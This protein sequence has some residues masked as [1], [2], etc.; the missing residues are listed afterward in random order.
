MLFHPKDAV[1]TSRDANRILNLKQTTCHTHARTVGNHINVFRP[2][3][4]L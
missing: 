3:F 4:E 1:A 2:F